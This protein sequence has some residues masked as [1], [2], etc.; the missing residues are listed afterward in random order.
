L[1][2]QKALWCRLERIKIWSENKPRRGGTHVMSAIF[3]KADI[4]SLSDEEIL[5][6]ANVLKL[7]N[8]TIKGMRIELQKRVKGGSFTTPLGEIPTGFPL[9]CS[10]E[11]IT[12]IH[13]YDLKDEKWDNRYNTVCGHP[14]GR[15][16][17]CKGLLILESQLTE[18]KP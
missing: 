7:K 17:T 2:F 9:V 4:R 1:N 11:G 16:K 18:V 14:I 5:Y 10:E 6:A 12:R 15:N 13:V 8:G 3:E